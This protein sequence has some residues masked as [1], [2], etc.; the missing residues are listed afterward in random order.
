MRN[1]I[2]FF[3]CEN[4]VQHF[5]IEESGSEGAFSVRV[6]GTD[7]WAGSIEDLINFYMKH[8]LQVRGFDVGLLTTSPVNEE[9]E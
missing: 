8:P 2:I 4:Q 1:I 7:Y 3:R 5:L 6:E 9:C